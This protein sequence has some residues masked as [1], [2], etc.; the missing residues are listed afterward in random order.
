M[1]EAARRLFATRG[2]AETRID[3]IAAEA[4]VSVPT[5]YAT[6]QSKRG[7]LDALIHRLAAGVPGGTPLVDTAGPRAV[8]A[9]P[10]AR[11]AL[12]MF[13]EHLLGVQ[14]RVIPTYEVMK[15]A[16]RT[17]PEIAEL[18]RKTQQ[19]RYANLSTLAARLSELDVLRAGVSVEDASRTLW[20]ITSPEVRQMLL[21][22]AGWTIDKYRA[23][24]EDTLVAVLLVQQSRRRK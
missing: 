10:D 14:E 4:D 21:D 7:V 20:A 16:A 24:L 19:Q 17:E 15:S 8:N 12:S 1:L 22:G 18:L 11:R 23:W 6:F 5:V 9:E 2:Y 13:V 3:D